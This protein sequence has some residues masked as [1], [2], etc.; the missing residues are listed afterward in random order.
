M[1]INFEKEQGT[2]ISHFVLNG[3][4]YATKEVYEKLGNE[5]RDNDGELEVRVT[6]NGFEVDLHAF[7]EMWQSQVSK[8]I[9]E[10][11][12]NLINNKFTDINDMLI[13]LEGR[14]ENEIDSRLEDW[15]KE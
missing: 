4:K 3:Y 15:E 6:V 13:N 14:I 9:T 8:M 10:E 7:V 1:R 12:K 11:A 2:L 5:M